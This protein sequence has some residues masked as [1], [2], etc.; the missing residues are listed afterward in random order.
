MKK[1]MIISA[2]IISLLNSSFV[3]ACNCGRDPDQTSQNNVSTNK[4]K[5][6]QTKQA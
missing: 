6:E 3:L 5:I 4:D 1:I 2:L